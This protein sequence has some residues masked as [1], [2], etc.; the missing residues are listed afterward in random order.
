MGSSPSLPIVSEL[1]NND[2][3]DNDTVLVLSFRTQGPV[4]SSDDKSRG[5]SGPCGRDV[6]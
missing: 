1:F 6:S 4:L 3:S 2:N 5:V